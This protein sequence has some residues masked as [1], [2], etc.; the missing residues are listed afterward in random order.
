MGSTF[1][2]NYCNV[3]YNDEDFY[4]LCI[5]N[6]TTDESIIVIYD[7]IFHEDVSKKVWKIFEGYAR[8]SREMLYKL[9]AKNC[10]K[11][12]MNI[13]ITHAEYTS[14]DHIN[15]VPR[16]N[17]ITNLR[18]VDEPTQQAN[19]LRST[20][21]KARNKE[22]NLPRNV[23]YHKPNNTH[24]ERLELEMKYCF[25]GDRHI[26][27]KTTAS[28]QL[29]IHYKI[30]EMKKYIRWLLETYP[31]ETAS[32]SPSA[33]H[34][35]DYESINEYNAIIQSTCF[36]KKYID[37]NIVKVSQDNPLHEDLSKLTEQENIILHR[38]TFSQ[39]NL[40]GI[41]SGKKRGMN[42]LTLLNDCKTL[43]R[44]Y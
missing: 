26:E 43:R 9:I 8:E 11:Y 4:A 5:I 20:C 22:L 28:T 23:I 12:G 17:R 34:E 10:S 21:R 15:R 18:Y 27:W 14:I 29:S 39:D 38:L 16:D 36:D 44:H 3:S 41:N 32:Y 7:A 40:Y 24:G 42:R 1:I 25:I 31:T 35:K 30:E 6:T 19:R 33:Y 2:N 13:H 37:A